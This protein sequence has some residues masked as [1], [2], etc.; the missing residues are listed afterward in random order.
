MRGPFGKQL[1]WCVSAAAGCWAVAAAAHT[2]TT[3]ISMTDEGFSPREVVA[4]TNA[5]VRFVN[6]DTVDHWPAS[7]VHPTHDLYPEFDPT[8]GIAPG[9]SWFF[10]PKR[11]GTW[12]YHDHLFPHRRGVLRV[13]GENDGNSASVETLATS[14][15]ARAQTTPTEPTASRGWIQRLWDAI[16]RVARGVLTSVRSAPA[17]SPQVRSA[18]DFR[19]LPERE[20]Y[21]YA[22]ELIRTKGLSAAWAYVKETYTND[23]GASLGGRAHDLAHFLG[24]RIFKERGITGLSVCDTTFAF[25]CYHGFTEAAF[26]ESLAPLQ[27][28]AHACETLGAQGSGPWSSCIHGIG[29]GVATYYESN[30]LAAAL[31]TCDALGNGATFCHDG[32]FMEMSFSASPS[33]YRKD[34][35]L[36]PCTAIDPRYQ[37][38]CARNQPQ[39]MQRLLGLDR[40]AVVAAC[41]TQPPAIADPCI[42][43]LGFAAA[44]ASQGNAENI[45]ALCRELP[46]PL[47]QAK[48]AAA[49]AGE[50]VFQNFPNWQTATRTVCDALPPEF[51]PACHQRVQETATNYRR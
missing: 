19:S 47:V 6:N 20:Q 15:E 50:L 42:D 21:A 39:I 14:P 23:A 8:K 32:V 10:R 37:Q 5:L 33:F 12:K 2:T 35:V 48:C 18:A 22:D 41:M 16:V 38:A 31:G 30:D 45:V 40:R 24:G 1:V 13:V 25:G 27:E 26:T 11:T 51:Q 34:D 3:I 36:Y 17:P 44:N 28:L 29:H 7:D 4:D 9:D 43:A 49:A 46:I